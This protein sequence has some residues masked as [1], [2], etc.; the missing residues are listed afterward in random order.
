MT[1]APLA[2]AVDVLRALAHP[3]RLR[4]VGMLASGPLSVCQITAVLG[5]ATSTVSAHL[6]AL[7]YAALVE[8]ERAG[9]FVSYRLA[10]GSAGQLLDNVR[11][12][13]DGNA[14]VRDDDDHARRLRARGIR[15]VDWA[16][17][18]LEVEAGNEAREAAVT[19][20]QK[21]NAT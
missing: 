16:A 1:R 5:G 18:C 9:R 13:L 3:T 15:A 21:G 12:L 8:H 2:R 20:A 14:Q 4:I 17:P 7:A 11:A 10:C 19:P 6:S